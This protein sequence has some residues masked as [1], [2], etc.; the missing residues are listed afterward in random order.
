[1]EKILKLN[2]KVKYDFSLLKSFEVGIVLRGFEVKQFKNNKVNIDEARIM[3]REGEVFLS[4]LV[5]FE[6]PKDMQKNTLHKLLLKK[7]EIQKVINMLKDK[8]VSGYVIEVKEINNLIKLKIGFGVSLKKFQK[9]RIKKDR[10][11]EKTSFEKEIQ[12]Y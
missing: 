1:M 8:K 11:T 5:F 4:R 3:L 6:T 2:K 10:K 12:K 7:I 9:K